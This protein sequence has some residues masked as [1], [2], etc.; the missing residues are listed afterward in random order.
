M[1]NKRRT[2]RVGLTDPWEKHEAGNRHLGHMHIPNTRPVS[3]SLFIADLCLSIASVPCLTPTV[4]FMP[5]SVNP[6]RSQRS[7]PPPSPPSPFQCEQTACKQVQERCLT[8]PGGSSLGH[9]HPKI[10]YPTPSVSRSLFIA[11][12][13]PSVIGSLTHDRCE[14]TANGRMATHVCSGGASEAVLRLFVAVAD[15]L[16]ELRPPVAE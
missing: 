3:H 10:P 11:F 14:Q 1:H 4:Y 12:P 7:P 15:R 2:G 5:L 9:V 16:T 13:C 6:I 8:K